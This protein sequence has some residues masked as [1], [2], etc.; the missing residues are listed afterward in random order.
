MNEGKGNT[1]KTKINEKDEKII[2]FSSFSFIFVFFVFPLPSGFLLFL[3]LFAL[4]AS[5]LTF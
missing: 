4:F 1:K 5:S 3:Q 2:N